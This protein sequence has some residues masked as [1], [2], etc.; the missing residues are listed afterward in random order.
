MTE[1]EW[2]ATFDNIEDCIFITDNAG[3]IKRLNRSLASKLGVKPHE[4]VGK[5]CRELF[6]CDRQNMDSC[7]L[8]RIQQGRPY[9]SQVV[10]MKI[11]DTCVSA[12]VYPVFN[13]VGDVDY[14]IHIY[15]D[16]SEQKRAHEEVS[17]KDCVVE[18][19]LNAIAIANLQGNITYINKSFL[20]LWGYEDENEVLGK[21]LIQLWHREDKAS[22][23]IDIT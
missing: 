4:L 5:S 1:K 3:V 16:I 13:A 6:E 15:R 9:I 18:S 23:V 2:E 11:F 10:E 21:S 17:P 19:A 14:A 8:F 20:K 22:E 12:H 7:S